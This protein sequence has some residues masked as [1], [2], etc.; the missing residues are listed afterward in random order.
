MLPREIFSRDKWSDEAFLLDM[1]QYSQDFGWNIHLGITENPN[2]MS[3]RLEHL[4]PKVLTKGLELWVDIDSQH[5]GD[6]NVPHN[7]ICF[8]HM[9]ELDE[10][11]GFSFLVAENCWEREGFPVGMKMIDVR[12]P[13]L[14][15]I[16][17][18]GMAKKYGMP[19]EEVKSMRDFTVMVDQQ[20]LSYRLE[21]G[22]LVTVDI[23][24]QIFYIDHTL[25]MLR[26]KDRMLWEG[27]TFAK[28]DD[29][30]CRERN[31]YLFTYDPQTLHI[32]KWEGS[33][34]GLDGKKFV[35]QLPPYYEMDRIGINLLAG[36]DP[37]VQL[38]WVGVQSH[39]VA[40]R[41]GTK[42]IQQSCSTR[43]KELKASRLIQK[44]GTKKQG[45]RFSR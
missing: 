34:G 2:A 19:I 31:A 18:A 35:L 21:K 13:E 20:A 39:F 24:G 45:E 25:Q 14:V 36:A 42:E 33:D 28:L 16:D 3:P 10:G 7:Q 4:L 29:C 23:L 22:K 15:K 17:P 32:T 8:S 41:V 40:D 30:Y 37:S 27:I 11:Y 1:N 12:I 43:E 44:K 9:E 38:K 26:P 5:V 6:I